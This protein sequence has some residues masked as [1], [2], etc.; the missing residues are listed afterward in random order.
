MSTVRI[1]GHHLICLQFFHGSGYTAEFVMNLIRVMESLRDHQLEIVDG[2]DDVCRSCPSAAGDACSLEPDGEEGIRRLDA[3]AL[4]LL[5]MES[6]MILEFSDVSDAIPPI[7]DRWRAMACDGC[8]WEDV[9]TP[10]ID[11]VSRMGRMGDAGDENPGILEPPL[12]P[13]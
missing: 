1:R 4:D 3:I 8:G 2:F 5:G 12:P 13:D 7:L 9:C 10:A 11:V 6:G